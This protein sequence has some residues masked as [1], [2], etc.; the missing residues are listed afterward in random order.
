[1]QSHS[2][3]VMKQGGSLSQ[4]LISEP[5][6]VFRPRTKQISVLRSTN[7]HPF[8]YNRTFLQLLKLTS[9]L[10]ICYLGS[11]PGFLS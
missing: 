6:G 11:V 1:M 9:N 5:K 2:R 10:M 4:V 7:I 8:D 3:I